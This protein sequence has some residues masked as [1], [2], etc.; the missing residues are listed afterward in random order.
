MAKQYIIKAN[1]RKVPFD[2]NKVIGTCVRV[3]TN[4]DRAAK[5]AK[6]IRTNL[7]SGSTTLD[8]YNMVLKELAF[9]ENGVS[10]KHRYR[11]K[12]SLMLLGPAGYYFESF[13]SKIL[14]N[15]DYDVQGTGILVQGNCV[16]H[17]IDIVAKSPEY[18]L[19][20]IECKYHNFRGFFTKL[21]ES[22][23]THARYMD[24]EDSFDGEMLVTNTKISDDAKKYANCIGQKL[25]AWKY[26]QDNGLERM[27]QDRG[28]FPI[29]MLRLKSWELSN[30]SKNGIM[31]I[32]DL[33]DVDLQKI[34]KKTKISFQ[35]LQRLQSLTRQILS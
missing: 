5:I 9:E 12:E 31:L 6:K 21:K 8:V 4:P 32:Q 7:H 20:L 1:G 2:K 11:L 22:L 18:N 30:F 26:P 29:T 24:L 35:R 16:R 34:S 3:G 10:L 19:M 15:Y 25:L 33:L 14:Q 17:E 13:I 23:Y 28:L 27:I